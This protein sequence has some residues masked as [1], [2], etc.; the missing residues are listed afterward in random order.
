[1]LFGLCNAAHTFQKF[2]DQVLCGLPFCYTYIDDV[3]IAS[4]TPAEHNEH[5]RITL[6]HL[7]EYGII[8]NPTKCVIGILSLHFL[9]HL[10]NSQGIL[11]LDEKVQ[12]I[13]DFP[14]PGTRCNLHKF[15]G[16]I[17][18]YYHFI[19]NCAQTLQPLNILLSTTSTQAIKW[20][21]QTVKVLTYIKQTLAQATLLFQPKKCPNLM[22][23]PSNVRSSGSSFA[24]VY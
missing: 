8:I 5:L 16:L 12:V 3:L 13:Q 2:M 20:T 22:T 6:S 1:M 21:E 18:I 23:D 19:P 15:L 17:N 7:K 10:V 4:D 11:L 24:A 14:Q 9:G